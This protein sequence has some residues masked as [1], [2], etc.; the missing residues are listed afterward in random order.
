MK[1][2]HKRLPLNIINDY[3]NLN[4]IDHSEITKIICNT[5]IERDDLIE[6]KCVRFIDEVNEKICPIQ[7]KSLN[8]FNGF[9]CI[10]QILRCILF[11]CENLNEKLYQNLESK[12][13]TKSNKAKMFKTSEARMDENENIE[14]Q[15]ESIKRVYHQNVIQILQN[16]KLIITKIDSFDYR[17]EI[18]ENIYALI[19]V[20][21]NDLFKASQDESDQ[22]TDDPENVYNPMILIE[23]AKRNSIDDFEIV[24]IVDKETDLSI[25]ENSAA[26][27]NQLMPSDAL[28]SKNSSDLN[29]DVKSR[30]SRR[31]R[32]ET[33]R[34]IED[35]AHYT[36]T[37]N[38]GGG[39]HFL[40]NDFLCRDILLVLKECLNSYS[41][42]DC[43]IDNF[44]SIFSRSKKL[45]QLVNET[46]WRFQLIKPSNVS[47]DF[48]QISI[49]KCHSKCMASECEQH[50]VYQFMK[51]RQRRDSN[52]SS[53]TNYE[54]IKNE[55]LT[56]S[57]NRSF[58]NSD[59]KTSHLHRDK[60]RSLESHRSL[61]LI[62][63][64][65]NNKKSNSVVMKLLC[66]IKTL[67]VMCL[68][69][70][71]SNEANQLVKIYSTRQDVAN[72]F[73]FEQIIFNNIVKES[74]EAIVQL[75]CLKSSETIHEQSLLSLNI[76]KII[77]NLTQAE[78]GKPLIQS[79]LIC[80]LVAILKI[81]M[82]I[83]KSL[84]EFASVNLDQKVSQV[85]PDLEYLDKQIGNKIN[86][87]IDSINALD[88][89]LKKENAL[90]KHFFLDYIIAHD[91]VSIL[92]KNSDQNVQ[93]IF[94][95]INNYLELTSQ[96][97]LCLEELCAS[98]EANLD[99]VYEKILNQLKSKTEQGF[100]VL[101]CFIQKS[102]KA[103]SS[104]TNGPDGAD[105]FTDNS[106]HVQFK[107]DKYSRSES[108]CND[109]NNNY[110][111][112]FNE[113]T[114]TL[115]QYLKENSVQSSLDCNFSI[116]D[117]SPASLICKLL[118][119]DLLRPESIEPLTQ[120]LNLNL[121][122]IIL[123]NSCP[124]LKLISCENKSTNLPR[125]DKLKLMSNVSVYKNE[126][127][128]SILNENSVFSCSIKKPHDFV[129]D[130]LF[131]VLRCCQWS[132]NSS[133]KSLLQI[134]SSTDLKKNL[135]MSQQLQHLNLDYLKTKNEKLSFFINL[136]NLL[137]IHAKIFLLSLKSNK[138]KIVKPNT[139]QSKL[140]ILNDTLALSDTADIYL[141]KNKTFKMLFEQKMCYKVGQMGCNQNLYQSNNFI[142]SENQIYL[143]PLIEAK[144]SKKKS[145]FNRISP[146]KLS[147]SPKLVSTDTDNSSN[148]TKAEQH[149]KPY[150]YSLFELDLK[151]EP[152][153]S[154]YIPDTLDHRIM[155]ALINCVQ[156]D[157]PICVYDSDQRLDDQL[158]MQMKNF[159]NQTVFTDNE[160][161][162]LY[163]PSLLLEN[164]FCFSDHATDDKL[165]NFIVPNLEHTNDG[166]DNLVKFLVD[167]AN[168]ELKENIK[169]LLNLDSIHCYG[170]NIDQFG[171]KELPF[172]IV[173]LKS[174]AKFCLV[175]DDDL[176]TNDKI[177]WYKNQIEQLQNKQN[178]VKGLENI[179]G[180]REIV[181][182][183][184][185]LNV[186]CLEYIS[187]S[188]PLILKNLGFLFDI[189]I[190]DD[191]FTAMSEINVKNLI[192][193]EQ[194][195][196]NCKNN[197]LNRFIQL[198]V[199]LDYMSHLNMDLK[200]DMVT[201]FLLN[202][203]TE[204]VKVENIIDLANYYSIKHEW[205]KVIDL[206][207][208]CTQDNE[209]FYDFRDL[210]Q[211]N[212]LEIS[213]QFITEINSL[214]INSKF[215]QKD[216]Y[217][218]FDHACL[219]FANQEAKH[220]D[221]S[222]YYLFKINNFI[223][224]IRAVFGLIDQWSIDGCLELVDFCIKKCQFFQLADLDSNEA[225]YLSSLIEILDDKK[226][227][228]TAYNDLILCAQNVLEKY[229]EHQQV[230][231]AAG[232]YDSNNPVSFSSTN[233]LDANY[234]LLN[235][236]KIKKVCQRCLTWQ[237]AKAHLQRSGDQDDDD[238]TRQL[239]MDLFLLNDKFVSAKYLIEK[240]CLDQKLQFKIEFGHLKFRLL[241]LNAVSSIIEIDLQSILKDCISFSKNNRPQ[242]DLYLFDICFKLINELKDF[243]DLNNQ[244]LISLSEFLIKNY[245]H[246]LNYHQLKE[247]KVI[248]LTAKMFQ[249]LVQDESV[250]F[251]S[252]KRHHSQPILII[253]QLL[254]NA[255]LDVCAKT[256]KLSRDYLND[257]KLNNDI[258][259]LL[260]EYAH[261]ALEFQIYRDIE[262]DNSE[263][264][265][266][267]SPN[268][269]R[270]KLFN[271]PMSSIINTASSPS[272]NSILSNFKSKAS[273][274][275]ENS[276]KANNNFVMPIIPPNKEDWIKDEQVN[277][278]MVCKASRFSLINRRHHCRRCGRVVCGACSQRST[279]IQNVARRTCDDCFRQ[280]EIVKENDQIVSTEH[281]VST[282]RT[283]RK[284]IVLAQDISHDSN[285]EKMNYYLIGNSINETSL[286]RDEEVRQNFRYSQAPS[287][288]LCLSILDLHDNSL[289]CGKSLL[290]LCDDLSLYLQNA[291][292]QED[293]GLVINMIKYLLQ[294]AKVKLLEN[295][296]SNIISLC[297]SYLSL[298]DVLEQ[299]LL[300]NC[301]IIP[302][303]NELMNS[304][305]V[306]RI[307]NRLLEE[308]RH[309]LAM[310]LSTKCGLDTQTVWASWGLVELK[311]SNYKEARTKF[312]K[313][314]KPLSEKN[315]LNN[316]AN[317]KI[318][319]DILTYF[320]TTAPIRIVKN[321]KN[322][323]SQPINIESLV[324]DPKMF[325]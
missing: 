143:S 204:E 102:K 244:V 314:L 265:R 281:E 277:D 72:L 309:E 134:Y 17:L 318:L 231:D 292:Q 297:D 57:L 3:L 248:Q 107:K 150:Q 214:T 78:K 2:L 263:Q 275:E 307:R 237:Y 284:S 267:K 250:Y 293:H 173:E 96:I 242:Y 80:D 9:Y 256:I 97:D 302:S 226:K 203:K 43:K 51:K 208:D 185:L 120:N 109:S 133:A 245:M 104:K 121:T 6:T 170:E 137:S 59:L 61:S 157:P 218:L 36:Y 303:L 296:S 67:S 63:P 79:I 308:E 225:Q 45:L 108:M 141:H 41:S 177:G 40:A 286:K 77:D 15:L 191:F 322:L 99:V 147:S 47:I 264:E 106:E 310:N 220:F 76:S 113:Y 153:W 316:S 16:V 11:C 32:H 155:F 193:Y 219:S 149:K 317:L 103:E 52:I 213:V 222:Y 131:N 156:S 44:Q 114:K 246:L 91:G 95:K 136:H 184:K 152:L 180:E 198:Y 259:I 304:E 27:L 21:S 266:N 209:E 145:I 58:K 251:D 23:N 111:M 7:Q 301:S 8:V 178:D 232:F 10:N 49:L 276:P 224:Q 300:A 271:K 189:R 206:L 240:F 262:S 268:N 85:N 199:P 1:I 252:Y 116:L 68:K 299:L 34:E 144:N 135:K 42:L 192:E 272:T 22:L 126:F 146:L 261:K 35:C 205:K 269:L 24:E 4:K 92:A 176:M 26:G 238:E 194:N 46:L 74:V 223:R 69:E 320:E 274:F 187:K 56:L 93:C 196:N 305:S 110:L 129:R 175:R 174:S 88:M 30:R 138:T 122:A 221:K 179:Q 282:K 118:F 260:V 86:V 154:R 200:L 188:S 25:Y 167:Q 162:I 324:S 5:L 243:N 311:R 70:F 319:N 306:R 215:I 94:E 33:N 273:L 139:N 235:L 247:L 288:S 211:V 186:E 291:N 158:Q 115:Y 90:R 98:E 50:L 230:Q 234:N 165:S 71:K 105:T 12:V 160:N 241:N 190:R 207:E 13:K 54:S 278:C 125:I 127:F 216:I 84:I 62:Y 60:R 75:D 18:L 315:A 323:L 257:S 290:S 164:L 201:Q 253:E 148:N 161:E 294:N 287:T 295:S 228:F 197:Y 239:I 312:E 82:H 65:S 168:A 124:R 159:L 66:D 236:N 280:L 112:S 258:N 142:S 151:M 81:D 227:E 31:S 38:A 195:I 289:E 28:I 119:D 100:D 270:P 283:K 298:I 87:Y 202:S 128:Y 325:I 29:F 229:Y 14:L 279:L 313:C 53:I 285:D 249:I 20:T 130:L 101:N 217:N 117:F 83:V 64:Q 212:N 321:I 171:R 182:S 210:T 37:K 132:K 172:P 169:K 19:F 163:V 140:L 255:K 254:M 183:K 48:G 39:E 181:C 123:H 73:E 166:L 55:N 89:T 233:E